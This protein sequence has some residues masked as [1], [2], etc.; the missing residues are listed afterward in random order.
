MLTVL[1]T[2]D[3]VVTLNEQEGRYQWLDEDGNDTET[4]GYCY[5]DAMINGL[6]AWPEGIVL[7]VGERLSTDEAAQLVPYVAKWLED[8]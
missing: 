5:K 3:G 4:S 8:K 6:A 2:P 1:I 7:V